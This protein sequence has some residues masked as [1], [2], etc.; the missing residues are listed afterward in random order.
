MPKHVKIHREKYILFYIACR[1]IKQKKISAKYYD[2]DWKLVYIG[3][4]GSVM[5]FYILKICSFCFVLS[6]EPKRYVEFN[7]A[8]VNSLLDAQY[9]SS[10]IDLILEFNLTHQIRSS[11]HHLTLVQSYIGK[12]CGR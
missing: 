11:F 8:V 10:F 5:K 1:L 7:F 3:H 9:S 2:K 12:L 4:F 6:V